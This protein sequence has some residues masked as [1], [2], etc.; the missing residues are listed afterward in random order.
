MCGHQNAG[1][2]VQRCMGDVAQGE[3]MKVEGRLRWKGDMG[4]I[5][6]VKAIRSMSGGHI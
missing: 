4:T 2:E 1:S 5:V 3:D 6:Q